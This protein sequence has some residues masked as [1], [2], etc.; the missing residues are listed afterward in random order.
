LCSSGHVLACR[1]WVCATKSC[2]FP[3]A[4]PPRLAVAN[5]MKRA[6]QER[7]CGVGQGA[8]PLVSSML[9]MRC[10]TSLVPQRFLSRVHNAPTPGWRTGGPRHQVSERERERPAICTS[11]L[12]P[13]PRRSFRSHS[14]DAD[15]GFRRRECGAGVPGIPVHAVRHP[16][17]VHDSV[18][19]YAAAGR[20]GHPGEPH[21][22]CTNTF[23]PLC[24]AA[25]LASKPVRRMLG[26]L[27]PVC[28]CLSG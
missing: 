28:Y 14:P 12:L 11:P 18:V 24:W 21:G 20:R 9:A 6:V 27:I 3:R 22:H 7:P 23:P 17:A 16:T 13:A 10:H 4:S 2:E 15:G 1:L 8:A 26:R 5:G 25:S 19:R